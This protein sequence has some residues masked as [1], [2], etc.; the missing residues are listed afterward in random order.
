M[1]QGDIFSYMDMCQHEKV[2]LQ[3]GMNYKINSEYSI[4]LMSLRKDAPY[5]DKI[6]KNGEVLIYEGHNIQKNHTKRD[7][8][9][10]DQP[11]F[12]PSGSLTQ[13][14]CFHHAA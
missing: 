1:K 4:I 7:P 6:E 8:K 13:N 11:E 2:T 14:G 9:T 12:N 10:I 5:A 3:R